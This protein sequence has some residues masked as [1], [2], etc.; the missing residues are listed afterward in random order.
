MVKS[1]TA[2]GTGDDTRLVT[3]EDWLIGLNVHSDGLNVESNHELTPAVFRYVSEIGNLCIALDSL[4]VSIF[5]GV[6]IGILC[7]DWVSFCIV[8]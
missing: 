7:S 6:G 3:S 2:V 5:S 8:E 4:A 1:S